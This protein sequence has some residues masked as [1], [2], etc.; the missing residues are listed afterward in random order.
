LIQQDLER[1]KK[2]AV[3]V[4]SLAKAVAESPQID[5]AHHDI[6]DKLYYVS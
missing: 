2:S 1:E 4:E 6:S 5:T 3:G